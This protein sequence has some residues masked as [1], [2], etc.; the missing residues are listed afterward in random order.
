VADLDVF[1]SHGDGGKGRRRDLL[2][3]SVFVL[4]QKRFWAYTNNNC[5]SPQLLP[6]YEKRAHMPIARAS[7]GYISLVQGDILDQ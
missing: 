1:R 6:S 5:P 3:L 2:W 4:K 7:V